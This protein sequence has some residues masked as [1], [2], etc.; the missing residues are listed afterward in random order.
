MVTDKRRSKALQ[1]QAKRETRYKEMEEQSR[2]ETLHREAARKV[3]IKEQ[4]GEYEKIRRETKRQ[5]RSLNIE[6]ASGVIDLIMDM[7]DE[8]FDVTREQPG[9]KMTKAQWREFSGLFVD[10]KK[11]TLR[12]IKRKVA[13]ADQIQSEEE[14]GALHISSHQSAVDLTLNFRK[15]P[16]LH[17]L[18]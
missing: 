3:Q 10:G 6:I 11:C 12:N 16:A 4:V 5:K 7:A 18:Y 17:D 1:I 9:N 2:A 15:E 8:V 14:D 13:G